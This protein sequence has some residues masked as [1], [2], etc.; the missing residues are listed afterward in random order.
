[1]NVS[2]NLSP[3]SHPWNPWHS[4]RSRTLIEFQKWD[5]WQSLLPIPCPH[6]VLP[7][8]F[9]FRMVM[10][11]YCFHIW[12][13]TIPFSSPLP[14][15]TSS[16]TSVQLHCFAF[17]LFPV[18]NLRTQNLCRM[19]NRH[20]I[21]SLI[22]K[23]FHISWLNMILAESFFLN[24]HDLSDQGRFLLFLMFYIHFLIMNGYWILSSHFLQWLRP[25]CDFFPWFCRYLNYINSILNVKFR[26]VPKI[27][28]FGL[29]C[30]FLFKI[31]PNL[32]CIYLV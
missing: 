20:G 16:F 29:V 22:E 4:A 5:L 12:G 25:S 11:C 9:R 7:L 10:G 23:L 19:F 32:I 27:K 8:L 13:F 1:M 2:M 14:A 24:T 28:Q 6:R 15:G 17:A 31:L 3:G 30:Y 26:W 18:R 21:S